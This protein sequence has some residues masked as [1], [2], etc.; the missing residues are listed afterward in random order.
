MIRLLLALTAAALLQFIPFLNLPLLWF[1]AFF[2][3]LGHALATLASGG[4]VQALFLYADGAGQCLSR[5][6]WPVLIGL[7]GYPAASLAGLLLWQ[8]V[9]RRQRLPWLWRGL[10][11]LVLGVALL[12]VRDLLTLALLAALV[13]GLWG[14]SRLGNRGQW[15][16]ALFSASL[17]VNALLSPLNLFLTAG[18]DAA[19]LYQLTTI[20]ATIFVIFWVFVGLSTVGWI[21]HQGGKPCGE[22]SV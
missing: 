19:L 21:V 8:G 3:E 2:H 15:L 10:A 18:G 20:P 17:L 9:Q 14:L 22:K 7:S 1:S 16:W 13:L 5:G 6:G 4:Q 11:L 12:W